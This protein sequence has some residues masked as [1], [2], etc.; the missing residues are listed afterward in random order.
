MTNEAL[1]KGQNTPN[2]KAIDFLGR[3]K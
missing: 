3:A 1:Q 2:T